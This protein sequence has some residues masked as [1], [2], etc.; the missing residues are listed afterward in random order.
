MDGLE[1]R[2]AEPFGLGAAGD[3][4]RR[5]SE[6]IGFERCVRQFPESH[7]RDHVDALGSSRAAVEKTQRT[8]KQHLAAAHCLQL[9]ERLVVSSRLADLQAVVSGDLVGADYEDGF[10]GGKRIGHRSSLRLGEP[11][12]GGVGRFAGVRGFV[13]RG[14]RNVE[15]NAKAFK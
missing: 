1:Q 5:F 13:D 4:V 9:C 6:K 7:A 8:M 15:W 14:H 2:N 3:V 11:Q 12:S 10:V